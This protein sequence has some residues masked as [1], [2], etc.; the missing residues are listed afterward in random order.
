MD[1]GQ[2]EP[3]RA[4]RSLLRVCNEERLENALHWLNANP[5]LT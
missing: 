4:R 5:F 3:V 2:N 1:D